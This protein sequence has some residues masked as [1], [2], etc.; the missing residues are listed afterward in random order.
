M[1]DV[2]SKIWKTDDGKKRSF[3]DLKLSLEKIENEFRL[4]Q[5]L[6]ETII[7][8]KDESP[9]MDRALRDSY[10]IHFR[11]IYNFFYSKDSDGNTIKAEDFFETGDKWKS[12]R[13]K[14]TKITKEI[15]KLANEVILSYSYGDD[16]IIRGIRKEDFKDA[17]DEISKSFQLFIELNLPVEIPEETIQESDSQEEKPARGKEEK[18]TEKEYGGNTI[19][20]KTTLLE[21]ENLEVQVLHA[22]KN[23]RKLID[24]HKEDPKYF[25]DNIEKFEDHQQVARKWLAEVVKDNKTYF[26][27]NRVIFVMK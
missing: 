21:N 3:K 1:S 6:N 4:L 2:I 17:V 22:N 8:Q 19:S 7:N 26:E 23:V 25:S 12:K 27:E 24:N 5:V 20:Y 11:R 15:E 9:E 14:E 13:F 10:L 16:A 18:V